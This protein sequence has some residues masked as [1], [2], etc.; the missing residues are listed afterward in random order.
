MQPAEILTSLLRMR[1]EIDHLVAALEPILRD[2]DRDLL[3]A[4]YSATRGETFTA[5]E[6]WSAA[7]SQRSAALASGED[8][9]DLPALLDV[10]GIE[11]AGDLGR[12]LAKQG[13]AV[14]RSVKS[15][16]GVIWQI[17]LPG[18]D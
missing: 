7:E 4:L 12:W 8:L 6:A 3:I 2:H 10:V 17:P 14:E 18:D 1:G 9:P 5:G 15:R 11:T 16:S 13:K